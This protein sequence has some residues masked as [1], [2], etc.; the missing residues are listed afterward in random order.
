MSAALRE[1]LLFDFGTGLMSRSSMWMIGID[2]LEHGSTEGLGAIE[3][4]LPRIPVCNERQAL[5]IIG[6]AKAK[7][8]PEVGE[9]FFY[10]ICPYIGVSHVLYLS[11]YI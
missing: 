4:L 10:Y 8:F 7:G 9:S 2:Y 3:L 11:I 1:S 5:K 6:V